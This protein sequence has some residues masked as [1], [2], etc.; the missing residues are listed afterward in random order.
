MAGIQ[1][2]RVW[3]LAAVLYTMVAMVPVAA[4]AQTFELVPEISAPFNA[5]S[6]GA[7]YVGCAWVDYDND[8]WQDAFMVAHLGCDLYHNN[9]N[10]TFSKVSSA[11]DA[12]TNFYRGVSFADYD[13]DGWIDCFVA[14]EKGTLYRNNNG[15][16]VA[17]ASGDFATSVA[18]AGWSPAWGDYDNDGYVDLYITLPNGFMRLGT[19]RPSRLY[20]ND[21]PPNFTFTRIDTGVVSTGLAPYTSANWTDFDQVGDLDLFVGTGPANASGG[22]DYIYRNM[23]KETGSAGFVRITTG[24]MATDNADGQVW[25]TIDYDND[26][27]LDGFRTN[28]GGANPALRP[29]NLYRNDGGTYV[30]VT[31]DPIVTEAKVSTGQVWADFDNDGDLDCFVANDNSFDSYFQNNGDG[32]FTEII[33]TPLNNYNVSTWGCAAG[34][35]DND[36]KMDL[37]VAG[38]TGDRSLLHNTTAG[39]NGWLEVKPVGTKANRAGIGVKMRVK[40]TIFGKTYWQ[41]REIS[42]QNSFLGH[43]SLIGHFGLGDAAQIDSLVLDWPSGQVSVLTNISPNQIVT[44]AEC[45]GPDT[46]GDGIPDVCDNCITVPNPSQ[47]D[48]DHDG[49]ADACDNCPTLANPGQIDFDGNGVGDACQYLCG[50]ANED[51]KLN[52][53]DAVYLINYIFKSGAAPAPL[54]KGDANHDTKVNVGDAVYHINYIFK[55]GPAP[56]LDCCP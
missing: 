53:G 3:L 38:P 56:V 39:S 47:V 35:Y 49:I 44:V 52:V 16:F 50:D 34:D 45:P 12:D 32:T 26:G 54:C 19:S 55:S 40:A 10:G 27:D 29:N 2:R 43:S 11:F 31:G 1:R 46:D 7:Q 6:T 23:L 36:G 25:N 15:V 5:D 30:R 13:N 14:G 20:H 51:K 9:G 8:G 48:T 17:A 28:W 33:G 21:G 22:T 42:A 24:P 18:S 4:L 41:L 37:L